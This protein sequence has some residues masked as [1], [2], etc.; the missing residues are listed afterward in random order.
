M[1]EDGLVVIKP[2]N[3]S[4]EE[5]AA[6]PVRGLTALN[7]LRKGSIQNGQKVLINGAS[8]STGTFAVQFA[9][10]FGA[11]NGLRT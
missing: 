5:A 8:G 6:V 11:S 2:V 1:P 4:Y 7:V 3:M 10:Y 9:K